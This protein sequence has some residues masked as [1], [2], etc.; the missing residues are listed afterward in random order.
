MKAQLL[1]L[2]AVG[3]ML[4]LPAQAAQPAIDRF[5]AAA[6]AKAEQRLT[7][8]GLAL[9]GRD[10]RIR[11]TVHADRRLTNV[12]VVRSSGSRDL[13]DQLVKALRQLKVDAP[14]VELIGRDVTLGVGDGDIVRAATP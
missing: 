13:D 11:A 2:S 4:A 10:A 1:M 6:E 14:P 8:E 12:R 7:A 5:V 9:Q 3:L